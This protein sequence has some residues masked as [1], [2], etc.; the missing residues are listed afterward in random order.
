MLK[1]DLESNS[2]CGAPQEDHVEFHC[3]SDIELNM[4]QS[5]EIAKLQSDLKELKQ[6]NEDLEQKLARKIDEQHNELQ[7]FSASQATVEMGWGYLRKQL[8]EFTLNTQQ[9][10]ESERASLLTRCILAEEQQARLQHY[11][12]TNLKSYQEEIVR[13]RQLLGNANLVNGRR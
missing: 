3:P 10:L 6:S 1:Y 8:R 9:E 5:R 13:L 2:G 7:S 4:A 12:D 11:I